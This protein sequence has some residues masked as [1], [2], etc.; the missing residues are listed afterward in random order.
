[1][2]TNSHLFL[3]TLEQMR[4]LLSSPD[5]E[6]RA[7]DAFLT[8]TIEEFYAL[9][10]EYALAQNFSIDTTEDPEKIQDILGQLASKIDVI[11]KHVETNLN[12]LNFV[13]K[14]TPKK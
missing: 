11:T 3:D 6:S 13:S 7:N 12:R 14:I 9:I 5:I 8:Q 4:E 10:D 2:T 1:M